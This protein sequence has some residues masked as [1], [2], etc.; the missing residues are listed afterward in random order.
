[1]RKQLLAFITAAALLAGCGSKEQNTVPEKAAAD[2]QVS[3]S[4]IADSLLEQFTGKMEPE[5]RELLVKLMNLDPE[6]VVDA[7]G[8]YDPEAPEMMMI[9]VESADENAAL[10]NTEKMEYYLNTVKDAASMYS[11]EQVQ[12]LEDAYITT[13]GSYSVLITSED[14]NAAKKAVA[15]QLN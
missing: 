13:R 8:Y 11:P 9:I 15:S 1:M 5:D 12:I 14:Q 4:S 7:K 2:I 3:A 10:D 6:T